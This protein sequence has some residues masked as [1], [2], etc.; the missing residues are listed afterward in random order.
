MAW[1]DSFGLAWLA[2]ASSV[3]V[4]SICLV[5]DEAG[6]NLVWVGLV[7]LSCWFGFIWVCLSWVRP[8]LHSVGLRSS[9]V[10][11]V[12]WVA[13]ALVWFV[14]SLPGLKCSVATAVCDP[15]LFDSVI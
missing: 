7:W 4:P 13:V 15:H 3:S 1:L 8:V 6:L 10:V 12:C 14:R 11:F 9:W 5:L 2:F